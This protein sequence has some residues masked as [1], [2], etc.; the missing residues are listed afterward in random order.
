[1][2]SLLRRVLECALEDYEHPEE[3]ITEALQHVPI[4]E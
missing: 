1:L 2:I 4:V 3:A